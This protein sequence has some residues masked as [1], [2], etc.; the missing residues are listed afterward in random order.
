M[1]PE[2]S[3][4]KEKCFVS[5]LLFVNLLLKYRLICLVGRMFANDYERPG[6]NPRSSH[7]KDFKMVLDTSLLS[8]L[9]YK[10]RMKG[11]VEQ[12]RER[13]SILPNTLV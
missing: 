3:A 11:K 12:S 2:C 5:Y 9:Q 4:I 1:K 13:S 8:T 10:V 6:F 7:T